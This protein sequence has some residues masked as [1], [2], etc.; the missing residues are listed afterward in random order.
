[1]MLP[2]LLLTTLKFRYETEPAV[3]TRGD[4]FLSGVQQLNPA[5]FSPNWVRLLILKTAD[6][7]TIQLLC[8]KAANG[9]DTVCVCVCVSVRV[10]VWGQGGYSVHTQRSHREPISKCQVFVK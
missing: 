5:E 4:G 9:P 8:T 10:C 3:W 1:M 6:R 7:P 2:Y